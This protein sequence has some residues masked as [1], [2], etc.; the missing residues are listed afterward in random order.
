MMGGGGTTVNRVTGGVGVF[1]SAVRRDLQLYL[2]RDT[3]P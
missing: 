2:R 3:L 1:G